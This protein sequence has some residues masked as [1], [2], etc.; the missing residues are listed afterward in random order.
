[1]RA[2]LLQ[3]ND[4]LS[5]EIVSRSIHFGPRIMKNLHRHLV[6]FILGNVPGRNEVNRTDFHVP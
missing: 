1:M 5:N 6:N 4:D 2:K 3:F